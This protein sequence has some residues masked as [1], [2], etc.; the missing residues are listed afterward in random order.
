MRTN[1]FIRKE[2]VRNYRKK[3]IKKTDSLKKKIMDG[4]CFLVKKELKTN[5]TKYFMYKMV[6][7]IHIKNIE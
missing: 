7:G 4:Q 5:E 2:A 6:R 1:F 3:N